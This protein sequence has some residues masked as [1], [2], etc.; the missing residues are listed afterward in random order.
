MTFR[1]LAFL[2][3]SIRF[4]VL[5]FL[6]LG[7]LFSMQNA[8][9]SALPSVDSTSAVDAKNLSKE[10]LEQEILNRSQRLDEINKQLSETKDNLKVTQTQR[11][12][13]QKEIKN[14]E[15]SISTL[16]LSIKGDTLSVEKLSLEIESLQLDISDIQETLIRKRDGI[17]STLRAMQKNQD[18][19][20]LTL[21]LRSESLADS[22]FRAQSISHIQDQLST[23]METLR[24]LQA[25]YT[26]KLNAISGKK[27]QIVQHK[28]DLE[29]KKYIVEDQKQVQQR[30]LK[31]TKNQ[32]TLYAQQLTKLQKEQ[33][34]I[35]SEIELLDATLRAKIDPNGLP[36][37]GHGVLGFPLSG[38]KSLMTQDYGSTSF[39][40]YGYRGKWHNG[41]DLRSPVGTSIM[42]A[43]SGT[44]VA[45]GDQDK[46]CYRGAYGR[47][48]VIQHAN[49]LT[50]L[51][52]HLSKIAVTKGDTV[53][54]GQTIGYVGS[55]G[56][57][58]GPHLH[59]TVF[60]SPTFSMGGSKTCGP[61]PHG[62]DLNPLN[63]L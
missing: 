30:V 7:F 14:L 56:Y 54:R 43:D 23:D 13:L 22:V 12:S 19:G 1:S 25:Q 51:Y 34:D 49:G 38:G 57:A 41:V 26:E 63:Y 29:N 46:Y 58:T 4:V 3:H 28:K 53:S 17:E 2:P 37:T 45:T 15:S 27:G 40:Q 8:A 62:G 52:A 32:E 44:V 61:M 9:Y 36:A 39:A 10:Q 6:G 5:V 50:T 42:A 16:Q 18:D 59:F 60:S 33:Q 48:I 35:A 21:L 24:D 20:L 31:Q 55:T 47:F 11:A